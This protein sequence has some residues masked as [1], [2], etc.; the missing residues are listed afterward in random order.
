MTRGETDMMHLL[1]DAGV[2]TP[3]D[4]THI[5]KLKADAILHQMVDKRVLHPTERSEARTYLIDALTQTNRTKQLHAQ[6]A[7]IN[8]ITHNLY[9][10]MDTASA[11]V[12]TSRD[13]ITSDTF[14]AIKSPI[15]KVEK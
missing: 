6:A 15:L 1:I 5:E 7:I 9:R 10:R 4:A 11:H 14:F 2:L 8:L 12:R 3:E 13:R